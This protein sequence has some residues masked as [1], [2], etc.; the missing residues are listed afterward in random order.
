[1][2]RIRSFLFLFFLFA[3]LLFW[4]GCS[5]NSLLVEQRANDPIMMNLI[6]GEADLSQIEDG[7]GL[8]GEATACP[9]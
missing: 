3:V 5:I 9:T 6:D 4:T 7:T 1:M 2:A 8:I